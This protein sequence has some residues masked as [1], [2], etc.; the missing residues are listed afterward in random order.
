MTTSGNRRVGGLILLA[1]AFGMVAAVPAQAQEKRVPE[2]TAL[3]DYAKHIKLMDPSSPAQRLT[4]SENG[5]PN[6][7]LTGYWPPT[8]EM[9]RQFSTNPEQN[10]SGWVGEDWEGRG[11]NIYAFF[12][13]FPEGLGKGEG[14][15]EVDYQDTSN[16][17]WPLVE[18]LQPLALLSFGLAA[19]DL[20]WR[21]EGGNITYQNNQWDNDYLSPR[22]PTYELPIYYE[23]PGTERYTT[24]P[25]QQIVAAL[26]ASGVNVLPV[27]SFLDFSRFL[28]DYMGYHVNWYHDLHADYADPAWTAAAGFIHVGQQVTLEN[29][30][31]ASEI[32]VRTLISHLDTLMPVPGD[33]DCSGAVDFDDIDAFVMALG[34]EEAYLQQYPDCR[35]INADC[36]GDHAINFDDIDPFVALL[37]E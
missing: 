27:V 9:L 29:A 17:F 14:D 34:G 33:L 21:L 12:P 2:G 18:Q 3:P 24:L 4:L 10:P 1:V 28:C 19:N 25:T 35:W 36:N 5:L 7:M 8:N 20:K 22:V 6:I 32:T 11:Y 31:L 30:I 13:E 15:F 26:T 37:S 23:T 16:D